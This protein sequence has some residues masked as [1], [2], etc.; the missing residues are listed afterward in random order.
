MVKICAANRSDSVWAEYDVDVADSVRKLKAYITQT[1]GTA[2]DR[3]Y[4]E[5]KGQELRNEKDLQSYYIR[6]GSIV[7]RFPNQIVVTIHGQGDDRE[8]QFRQR[9]FLKSFHY[10]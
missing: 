7:E 4:F 10:A 8:I 9:N 3:Q 5:Y 2:I 1:E 6:D